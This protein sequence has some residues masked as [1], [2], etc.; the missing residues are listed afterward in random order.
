MHLGPPVRG[1]DHER[2][3]PGHG[4]GGHVPSDHR[5]GDRVVATPGDGEGRER[6]GPVRP[7]GREHLLT[8]VVERP[9]PAR[10]CGELG[11]RRPPA[12]GGEDL[13]RRAAGR[14]ERGGLLGVEHQIGLVDDHDLTGRTQTGQRHGRPVARRQHDVGVRTRPSPANPWDNTAGDPVLD[15][16]TQAY[17]AAFN[18]YA[19]SELNYHTELP[20][21]VLSRDINR[22]WSWD[23]AR[24]GDDGLGLALSGLQTALLEHPATKVLIANG[25]YDLMTPYLDRAG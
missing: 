14:G 15:N 2:A 7:D 22:Q 19:A 4:L 9:R 12:R 8:E 3:R 16:A 17:T 18:A 5:A 6:A 11:E 20:Y 13:R 24:H 25:R 10:G 1:A 21:R 23:G